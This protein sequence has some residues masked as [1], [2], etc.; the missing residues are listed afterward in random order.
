MLVNLREPGT[1]IT[2][3]EEITF[4][5]AAVTYNDDSVMLSLGTVLKWGDTEPV[6]YT[7]LGCK[8]KSL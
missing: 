3:K 6:S 7:H 5:G 1:C 2:T 8:R 4:D